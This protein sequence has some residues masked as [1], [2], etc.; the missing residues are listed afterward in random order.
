MSARMAIGLG[1]APRVVDYDPRWP[2]LY[3]EEKSRVLT[4]LG[5]RI[6]GIEHI[7]S[8]AVPGLCA[9]PI[10][11]ILIGLRRLRDAKGCIPRLVAIGYEYVPEYEAALPERRY[12]R[13]GSRE[14]R[15]HHIHMV[16][17]DSEFYRSHVLFR[18][19]LRTHPEDARRYNALKR[20]LAV[21]F[22]SDR[23][24]YTEAKAPFI[25]EILAKAGRVH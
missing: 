6:A 21:R 3:E 24:G 15:T 11:D 1:P 12:L 10:L 16:E 18:D 14:N 23:E 19:H 2:A 20:E 25:R 8:T 17:R 7:G 22:A 9:K 4:A 13:K 5:D